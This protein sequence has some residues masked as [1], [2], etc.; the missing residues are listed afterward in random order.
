MN[1]LEK[2]QYRLDVFGEYSDCIKRILEKIDYVKSIEEA[3][4]KLEEA[5]ANRE[6]K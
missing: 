1:E 5:K 6:K 4:Q 2:H 3:K